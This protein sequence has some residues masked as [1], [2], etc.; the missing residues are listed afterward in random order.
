MQRTPTQQEPTSAMPTPRPH[1]R[2]PLLPIRS[3]AIAA[4]LRLLG[5]A[6]LHI[7]HD[8]R[9]GRDVFVFDA[10]TAQ[11]DFDRLMRELDVLRAEGERTAGEARADRDRPHPA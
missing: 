4:H 5:N 3:A 2:T 1:E 10:R 11:A 9:L 7:R 8:E 6:V